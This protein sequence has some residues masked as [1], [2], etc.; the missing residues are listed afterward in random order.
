MD[1]FL[2][3]AE[4]QI[5]GRSTRRSGIPLQIISVS[6]S[7]LLSITELRQNACDTN[8]SAEAITNESHHRLRLNTQENI[9]SA[10]LYYK[11]SRN[12]T[13]KAPDYVVLEATDWL[14]CSH[15][16]EGLTVDKIGKK[17]PIIYEI[18]QDYL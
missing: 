13:G 4:G 10:V 17:R 2:G 3:I 1:D 14:K 18:H 7:A 15:S 5:I 8:S 11:P 9:R 12:Q 6:Q 16:L